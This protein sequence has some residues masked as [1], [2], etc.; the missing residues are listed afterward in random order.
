MPNDS[1][2]RTCLIQGCHDT[3]I[4]NTWRCKL[5]RHRGMCIIDSCTNQAYARQL[6]CRHGAKKECAVDG[7]SLRARFD[8]VCYKHGATKK[9]CIEPGCPQPAQAR[10]R[11][12]KHGGGRQCKFSGCTAHARAGGFCQRHRMSGKLSPT[13]YPSKNGINM[14]SLWGDNATF[15]VKKAPASLLTTPLV[16][17][18]STTDVSQL[19][20]HIPLQPLSLMQ[21]IHGMETPQP[22]TAAPQ[23]ASP[24][25]CHGTTV[26]HNIFDLL[27]DI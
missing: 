13:A 8:N 1:L 21:L 2:L 18:D 4:P 14:M 17:I 26:L 12:V 19:D 7:C 10:Q 23:W 16:S 24:H 9:L 27:G 20:T 11:C 5:H 3:A 15:T 25:Y 22:V 6:C